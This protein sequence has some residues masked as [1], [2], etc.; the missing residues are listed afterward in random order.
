MSK[1]RDLCSGVNLKTEMVCVG[2][3]VA[4]EYGRATI[5]AW[6][7]GKDDREMIND[8]AFPPASVRRADQRMSRRAMT[9]SAW[10]Y[11]Y[12]I[13]SRRARPPDHHTRRNPQDIIRSS[14]QLGRELRHP[15][16]GQKPGRVAVD[17]WRHP[18]REG[19]AGASGQDF[20]A[21]KRAAQRKTS[22]LSIGRRRT[23]ISER[24]RESNPIC[25][26]SSKD[27]TRAGKRKLIYTA[28]WDHW[29]RER[30][31]ATRFQGALDNASGTASLL[32]LAELQEARRAPRR[33]P[34]PR[35]DAEEGCSERILCHQA[36][37]PTELTLANS[38]MRRRSMGAD[39]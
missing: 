21:R 2:Y 11:T 27:Q 7:C 19:V 22:T 25:H 8:P 9:Y 26:R 10:T 1:S 35:R 24:V 13:A 20:A 30:L 23:Y 6:M 37:L 3:G 31:G 15:E 38:N 36:A 16:A 28:H 33:H 5:K 17:S 12:E 14:R 29:A 34:L 39:E 4:T 18:T 32:E